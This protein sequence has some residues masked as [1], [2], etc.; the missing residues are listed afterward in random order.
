MY[1]VS[2]FILT[3]LFYFKACN[4]TGFLF[5]FEFL[6]PAFSVGSL[7]YRENLYYFVV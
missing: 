3:D 5:M 7:F 6:T 1:K 2:D 4:V